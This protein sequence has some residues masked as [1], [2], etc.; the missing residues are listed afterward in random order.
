MFART[1]REYDD[2]Q[3]GG[4]DVSWPPYGFRAQVLQGFA[5]FAATAVASELANHVL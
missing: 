4:R 3:K 2:A 5:F 1:R